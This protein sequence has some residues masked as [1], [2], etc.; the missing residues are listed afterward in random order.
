MFDHVLFSISGVET[1]WWLPF[2]VSFV[3]A[4][5]CSLAGLSGAF[6][7]LPFQM[8]VL[9]YTSLGVSATNHLYNSIAILGGVY[10]LW[11]EG[12]LLWP[13]AVLLIIGTL[14]GVLLGVWV[15]MYWM[16]DIQ[17]FKIFVGLVLLF[18]ALNLMRDSWRKLRRHESFEVR[19]ID[20]RIKEQALGL[21]GISFVFNGQNYHY[22]IYGFLVLAL[23]VGMIGGIYGIGGG[24]IIAPFIVVFYRIPVYALAAATLLA[25]MATS[26]LG[27]I[28]FVAIA[29]L[30]KEPVGPDWFLGI[31]M[32]L[33]GFAGV[34]LGARMQHLVKEKYLRL[35][36]LAV[37]L[38]VS[39][40]YLVTA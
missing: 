32:G 37:L 34:Y 7:L 16:H 18:I 2:I 30:G 8:S 17:V 33:G 40:S 38:Y 11:R 24:A 28:F 5:S 39:I 31:I 25:T 35:L 3:V 20:W 9:G 26:V 13:L 21:Q 12:R 19:C 14:P 29:S 27:V 22:G 23:V 4:G 36:L 10:R 1:W 6:L 15:R